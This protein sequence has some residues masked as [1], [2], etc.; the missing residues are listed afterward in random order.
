[1]PHYN[2]ATTLNE[3]F[4]T[5]REQYL[6]KPKNLEQWFEA[7]NAK[8]KYKELEK[9]FEF[10]NIP[11]YKLNQIEIA[12][13]LPPWIGGF[14]NPYTKKI[15]INEYYLTATPNVISHVLIHESIHAGWL[16]QLHGIEVMDE[17][18]TEL[19]TR[20]L[21]RDHFGQI[22]FTSGYV[23]LVKDLEELLGNENIPVDQLTDLVLNEESDTLDNILEQVVLKPLIEKFKIMGDL[24]LLSDRKILQELQEK[25]NLIN[26]LFPR[27]LHAINGNAQA[28]HDAADYALPTFRSLRLLDKAKKA[29]F[30]DQLIMNIIFKYMLDR[31][32]EVPTITTPNELLEPLINCLHFTGM[33]YLISF[34][35]NNLLYVWQ[36]F[37][38]YHKYYSAPNQNPQDPVEA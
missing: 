23:G 21:I 24:E 1:M 7:N 32:L 37:L 17:S 14:Y 22:D 26:T 16:G 8:Y 35:E 3:T 18:L 36:R 6:P 25:W 11:K 34:V 2:S 19:M 13:G 33:D 29:I 30:E 5:F 27:L 9:A 31:Y 15:A 20:K 10:A 28:L 38:T 4:P 12:Y